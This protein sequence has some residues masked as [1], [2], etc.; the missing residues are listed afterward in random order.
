MRLILLILLFL[1]IYWFI[2]NILWPSI[3]AYLIIRKSQ[4]FHQGRKQQSRNRP[5]GHIEVRKPEKQQG[6][7]RKEDG[8]YIDFDEV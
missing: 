7:K 2:R 5:E 4:Q 1:F 3:K 8:E 6:R